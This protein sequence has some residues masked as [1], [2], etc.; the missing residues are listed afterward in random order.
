MKCSNLYNIFASGLLVSQQGAAYS[1]SIFRHFLSHLVLEEVGWS[2]MGA[3]RFSSAF[4][5]IALYFDAFIFIFVIWTIITI[6]TVV[7]VAAYKVL[8]TCWYFVLGLQLT[9]LREVLFLGILLLFSGVVHV[10][11]IY[12]HEISCTFFVLGAVHF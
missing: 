4:H 12:L 2:V 3:S 11:L 1:V 5:L 9:L 8:E 6:W 7:V 10:K